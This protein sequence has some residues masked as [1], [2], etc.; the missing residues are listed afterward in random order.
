MIIPWFPR[1]TRNNVKH[2]CN[3]SRTRVRCS[4]DELGHGNEL[5]RLLSPERGEES[6]RLRGSIVRVTL[7]EMVQGWLRCATSPT[8]WNFFF[9]TCPIHINLT[10]DNF[11]I[12][13]HDFEYPARSF[14]N[15]FLCPDIL[16]IFIRNYLT[17]SN[18]RLYD[19]HE[20]EKLLK[21]KWWKNVMD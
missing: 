3:N 11:S 15:P 14:F 13:F 6:T 16:R 7:D 10:V 9:S 5:E 8:D 20:H 4:R 1:R 2:A 17:N 12:S 18:S 21:K 19:L